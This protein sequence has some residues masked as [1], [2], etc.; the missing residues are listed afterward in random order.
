MP[1][2]CP[3]PARLAELTRRLAP[4]RQARPRDPAPCFAYMRLATLGKTREIFLGPQTHLEPGLAILDWRHAPLAEVF[5]A[6]AA[7][8]DY[9]IEHEGR[10]LSGTLQERHLL[11]WEDGAFA[12]VLPPDHPPPLAARPPNRRAQ[13]AFA[14]VTL[15]PEQRAVVELPADRSVL[16]LGE[17]GFG[18][19]TVALHRLVRLLAAEPAK[20][21]LVLVPTPGLATLTR[22]VLE[23]LGARNVQVFA[24]DDW[25][26]RE[27]RRA[28]PKLPE[29]ESQNA[30]AGVVRAKRDRALREILSD[31][32]RA[33]TKPVRRID[34]LRLFGD[35]RHLSALRA[36]SRHGLPEHAI[37]E[38]LE[39]THVQFSRTA[40]QEFAHVDAEHLITADGRALDDGTPMEDAGT[41]DVEDYAVLFE[42]D[43]LRAEAT[44]ARPRP[45]GVHDVVV[46]D[47]AQEFGALE[48]ALMGR[49]RAPGG[50]LV[51]A[52]DAAQQVD[53][54]TTFDGW[55][56]AMADLAC[57]E[58]TPA[59]LRVSYRCPPDVT[60]LARHVLGQASLPA[61]PAAI[62]Y[63]AFANECH[64]ADWLIAAGRTLLA[65]DPQATLAILCRSAPLARAMAAS[66][67]RGLALRL[68]EGGDFKFTGGVNVASVDEVKGLE[69]D[70]VILPDASAT[71]YPDTALSRR[72]LYVALT[73]AC[74]QLVLSSVDP[75]SRLLPPPRS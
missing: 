33:T 32:A 50:T 54:T 63:Y 22:A 44:G 37:A 15:D 56:A 5:F 40:E 75:P 36:R 52:G 64:Q 51:V 58:Y 24:Y 61:L 68:A 20:T 74:H 49:A 45:P 71:H 26:R 11:A 29:R 7:G 25:A 70:Y 23:R 55:T 65:D 66:L 6:C 14:E 16:L 19:T 72:A 10:T 30:S 34:L 1:T 2:P 3:S 62:P 46:V 42:W 48:L 4:L 21:G 9:E 73:R 8:E 47:E 59:T 67:G 41:V 12:G 18:K 31:L 38:V 57:P 69:F 43:R 17:A 35:S 60:D 39:H 13:A 28:F 53:P 27:A